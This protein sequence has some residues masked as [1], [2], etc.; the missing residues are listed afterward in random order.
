MPSSTSSSNQRLPQLRWGVLLSGG[1]L[2]LIAFAGLLEMRLAIR[3]YKPAVIDSAALWIRE[4]ARVDALG[5]RA[6]VLVGSS[7]PLLDTDLETLRHE[8]GLEPVQLAIDGSSFMPVLQGLAADPNVRGTVLV[9]LAENVLA[10]PAQ[11]DTAYAYEAV[12][13]RSLEHRLPDFDDSEAYL[14]DWLHGILRSYA[15]GTRPITALSRRVLEKNPTPQYLRMLP[16]RE[17][18]ADYSDVPQ[19]TFYYYRVI[20]NL[21][22]TVPTQGRSYRDI[23]A[24]FTSRIA[25]LQPYD[26]KLF[27]QTLPSMADMTEAIRRHGGRV[28]FTTYPTGGY[29]RLIDDKRLPRALFWD[30]FTAAVPAQALNFEDVPALRSF[31]FPDGSHLDEHDRVRFTKTLVTALGLEAKPGTRGPGG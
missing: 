14:T 23:E 5:S 19:P 12:Y 15:D 4:R 21:G 26:N 25:A 17:I 18:L 2:L 16:D 31:Y 27:L 8:T 10:L 29:V 6:L 22:Q 7:R 24:D 20:R 11:P 9:D 30:R 13:E 3:G 28:I 1:L